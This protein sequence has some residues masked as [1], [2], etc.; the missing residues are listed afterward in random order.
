[1]EG[2][3]SGLLCFAFVL[4]KLTSQPLPLMN[5][6]FRTTVAIAGKDFVVVASDTRLS[7]GF[8]IYTR[9]RPKI[10]KLFVFVFV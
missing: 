10:F 6:S 4:D 9:D 7:E 8:L 1:M 5:F 2:E 3:L